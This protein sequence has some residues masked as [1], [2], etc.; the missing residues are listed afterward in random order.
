MRSR[1][2]SEA[3]TPLSCLTIVCVQVPVRK[4]QE[5]LPT[6]WAYL[7]NLFLPPLSVC[8]CIEICPLHTTQRPWI[9][10]KDVCGAP[11]L[12]LHL[13]LLA[14]EAGSS[15]WSLVVMCALILQGEGQAGTGISGWYHLVPRTIYVREY[16]VCRSTK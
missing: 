6:A 16:R 12:H 7:I 11:Y 10:S 9:C 5:R 4:F 1:R 13:T 8:L 3:K 2:R 14:P 15:S